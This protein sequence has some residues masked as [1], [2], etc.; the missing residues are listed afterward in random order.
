MVP[1]EVRRSKGIEERVQAAVECGAGDEEVPGN[2]THPV[3][4]LV[5]QGHID[6][7]QHVEQV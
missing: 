3:Q 7:R 2:L 4:L 1:A 5:L 6:R